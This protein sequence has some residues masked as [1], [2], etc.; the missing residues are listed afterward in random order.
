MRKGIEWDRQ[1]GRRL[2]LRD[3][4]VFSAVAQCGSMSKAAAQL[5]VSTPTVSELI[6]H[7][8]HAIGVRLLDRSP[9]GVEPTRYGQA[10]LKRT[11]IVFDELKEGIKDIE[12]LDDPTT[13]EIRVAGP[14][15][16]AFTVI[17]PIFE[18]FAERYPRVV[19]GFDEVSPSLGPHDLRQL[20]ERKYD[21]ILMRGWTQQTGY[22]SSDDLNVIPLFDDP[23]AIVVGAKSKWAARRKIDLVEL[24]DEPW[25]LQEPE[26]WNYQIL[27]EACHA[28]GIDL[29][30]VSVVTLSMAVITRFLANGRFIT[31]MPRSMAYFC[32]LKILP[33]D[34]PIRPWPINIVTLKNRTLSPVIE[35]FIQC[36][37]EVA[38]SIVG[39]PQAG[40]R[41]LPSV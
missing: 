28:R 12:F 19:L 36:A 40:R 17:S 24:I 21:L 22:G 18:R 38:K 7:L 9:R 30:K 6:A 8:E 26:T 14:A 23:L 16:I 39:R 25:I 27:A 4:H 31:S 10:L 2:R 15:G 11:L 29:P 41:T 32:S 13:G 34:L 3:L 35:R 33:V 1:I 37:R 20:R 5:G